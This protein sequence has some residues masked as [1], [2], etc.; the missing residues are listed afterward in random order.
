LFFPVLINIIIIKSPCTPIHNKKTGT[1]DGITVPKPIVALYRWLGLGKLDSS[2]AQPFDGTKEELREKLI[3][4]LKVFKYHG[5]IGD[6]ADGIIYV[7]VHKGTLTQACRMHSIVESTFNKYVRAVKIFIDFKKSPCA[8]ESRRN[9][10]VT[11]EADKVNGFIEPLLQPHHISP[12][13]EAEE[14]QND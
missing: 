6:L 9:S 10:E 14:Q 3:T 2:K 12:Q 7:F 13:K 1:I 11:S 4:T 5:N 8:I